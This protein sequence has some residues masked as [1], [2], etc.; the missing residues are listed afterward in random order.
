MCG[1]SPKQKTAASDRALNRVWEPVPGTVVLRV[2]RP[3]WVGTP[4]GPSP[5]WGLPGLPVIEGP[6]Q[7]I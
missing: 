3:A 6:F 2:G 7:N 5:I 4:V 1:W